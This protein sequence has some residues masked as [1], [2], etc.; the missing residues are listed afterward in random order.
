[1][2]TEEIYI[3]EIDKVVLFKI[4]RN[5]KDNFDIIDSSN[6]N[7]IWFH[8]DNLPSAHIISSVPE[9]MNKK[10]LKY[11]VKKGAMLCKEHSKYQNIKDLNI[12]YTMISNVI[13]TNIIGTVNLLNSKIIKI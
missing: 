4:G 6:K 13:K 8:V 2:K 5:A 1:M 11:I 12:V 3:K 10:E 9:N 7:D